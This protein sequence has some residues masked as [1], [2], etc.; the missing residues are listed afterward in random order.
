MISI[1]NLPKEYE[2]DVYSLAKAFCPGEDICFIEGAL[3]AGD[4]AQG[5]RYYVNLDEDSFRLEITDI[6][7]GDS[8]IYEEAPG[9]KYDYKK[10]I[11][12]A[13]NDD[14]MLKVRYVLGT[15]YEQTDNN[16]KAIDEYLK[17]LDYLNF[18][19]TYSPYNHEHI[20]L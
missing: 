14:D 4:D 13:Q 18:H 7:S 8:R 1:H 10:A 9:E 19:L 5:T 2:Y 3:D 17:I 12:A 11:G 6:E 16:L 15:L 20:V